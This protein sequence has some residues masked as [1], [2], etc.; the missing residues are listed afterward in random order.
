MHVCLTL[1]DPMDCSPQDLL[2]MGFPRQE[3]CSG[4]PFPTPGDLPDPS[5]EPISLASST[6]AG[7]YLPLSHQGNPTETQTCIHMHTHIHVCAEKR[8]KA[9]YINFHI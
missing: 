3:Y 6:L 5:I 7:G 9:K 8:L 2:S 1:C 4:L